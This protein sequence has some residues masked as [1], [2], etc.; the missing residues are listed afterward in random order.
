MRATNRMLA[1]QVAKV[2]L[3]AV[4]DRNSTKVRH[5]AISV[6]PF[7][8]TLPVDCHVGQ[9]FCYCDVN[10]MSHA[11]N[12]RA[13][14]IEMSDQRLQYS[15]LDIRLNRRAHQGC[16]I[17]QHCLDCARRKLDVVHSAENL[18]YPLCANRPIHAE[19]DNYRNQRLI[20]LDGPPE[21]LRE[22]AS[23]TPPTKR[24]GRH[25]HSLMLNDLNF[26]RR[27]YDISP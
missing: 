7:G 27:L 24:A 9:E 26:Y 13:G 20:I 19:D 21:L 17:L 3:P 15:A 8:P 11:I 5:D 2:H 23:K 4:V 18:L 25:L 12:F 16:T 10:P 14:L 1:Q 22:Y 6:G